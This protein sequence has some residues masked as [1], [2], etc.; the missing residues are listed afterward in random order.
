MSNQ[1]KIED[2]RLEVE[3]LKFAILGLYSELEKREIDVKDFI[4]ASSKSALLQKL[5]HKFDEKAKV[6]AE[7][8]LTEL[9]NLHKEF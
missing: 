9:L 8:Y 6:Q 4:D 3:A 1:A 2:F 5:H 7:E